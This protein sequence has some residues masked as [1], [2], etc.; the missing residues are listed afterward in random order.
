M[1]ATTVKQAAHG[2]K[3]YFAVLAEGSKMPPTKQRQAFCVPPLISGG[4]MFSYRCSNACRHCLYRCSPRQ[5]EDW[6]TVDGARRIFEALQG[7]PQLQGLHLAGGEAAI[8]FDVLEQVVRLAREM[9]MPVEYVETNAYWC[10]DRDETRD[11]MQRLKRA[12][13][14]GL[15]VSASMFHNEFVPFKRTRICVETAQE[16]FGPGGTIVYLPHVYRILEQLGDEDRTRTIEEFCAATDLAPDGGELVELYGVIPNGRVVEAL[17]AC[18]PAHPARH[19]AHKACRATLA[20]T[21][22]FHIDQYGNLFTG[23]CAG[24]SVGTT[25]DLHPEITEEAHPVFHTLS[26][27][28]PCGLMRLAEEACGFEETPEGYISK[29]DLCLDVR[30]S[31]Y[32]TGRY[33][34]LRPA[35]FYET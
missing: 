9:A 18:Y 21:T 16:V 35:G 33:A 5:P 22:H 25:E 12:G 27:G 17:R 24:I 11:K 6:L 34:E 14:P 26:T 1:L 28:G 30:G 20:S 31:L 10:A 13:L 23:F 19:F 8:H 32:K 7:E 29:C 2:L 3:F 15:L 4:I